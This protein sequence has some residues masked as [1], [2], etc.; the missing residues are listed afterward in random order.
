MVPARFEKITYTISSLRYVRWLHA[1]QTTK[2][3]ELFAALESLDR[4]VQSQQLDIVELNLFASDLA[5]I[6][7]LKREIIEFYQKVGKLTPAITLI[8]QPPISNSNTG[9]CDTEH[10][11]KTDPT[12]RDSTP[13]IAWEAIGVGAMDSEQ[14]GVSG[15]TGLLSEQT[16]QREAAERCHVELSVRS[17]PRIAEVEYA[18]IR[19]LHLAGC[20]TPAIT[21]QSGAN[22]YQ[23]SLALF[24]EM[25]QNLKTLLP[26]TVTFGEI[27]RTWLYLGDIV[28]SLWTHQAD[29]TVVETNV[30]R[31]QELNRARTDFFDTVTFQT[32]RIAQPNMPFYPA[33][34]G[35]GTD[36]YGVLFAARALQSDRN[37]LRVVALENPRQV[38]AFDYGQHYS[39]SSPKF[40]RAA[41][42]IADDS[43]VIFISGTASITDSESRH[44]NDAAKQTEETLRNVATLISETNFAAHAYPGYGVTLEQLAGIRVYVKNGGDYAQIR[45][46]CEREIPRIP[47]IYIIGD[48]CRSELLVEIEGIAY[49]V[50]SA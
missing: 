41:A 36:G 27:V 10:P 18:G 31:Y 9:K 33:S 30:Q 46:V 23:R 25:R 38:S 35:I 40:S 11:N 50:R 22:V 37:D 44:L 47:T 15:Q 34:T 49:S 45:Q 21:P 20:G 43:A 16:G 2:Q 12:S 24:G 26:P 28:G 42:V 8:P 19:W 1:C 29:Q 6:G 3:A 13:L 17:T 7:T 4:L 5:Q 48:V 39:P 14:D 32:A